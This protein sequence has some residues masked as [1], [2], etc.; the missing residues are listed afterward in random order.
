MTRP[1]GIVLALAASPFIAAG[2]G[3]QTAAAQSSGVLNGCVTKAGNILRLPDEG[4]ACRAGETAVSWNIQGPQGATGATGATGAPGPTGATGATG[5]QGPAGPAG[6]QTLITASVLGNGAI[7]VQSVPAGATLAV[8]RTAVGTYQ[9]QV[10]GLG[11]SC[12]L[13]TA[14]PFNA[15]TPMWLGSGSCGAGSLSIPLHAGNNV[16]TAFVMTIAALGASSSARTQAA[17]SR[18]VTVLGE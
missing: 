3:L 11:T 1:L 4:V 18:A 16:D 17:A 13:L 2:L 9:I 15:P 5:P 6:P 7:Q 14:I 12:P 8:S 10:T